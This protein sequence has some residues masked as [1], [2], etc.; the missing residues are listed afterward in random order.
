MQIFP[1][2]AFS[3]LKTSMGSLSKAEEL[4]IAVIFGSLWPLESSPVGLQLSASL[5]SRAAVQIVPKSILCTS[6]TL[7]GMIGGGIDARFFLAWVNFRALV[8]AVFTQLYGA[9]FP[10]NLCW[11]VAALQGGT[12]PT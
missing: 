1:R 10:H 6:F 12:L 5:F 2:V 3:G 9:G 11:A 4:L 8:L 7:W